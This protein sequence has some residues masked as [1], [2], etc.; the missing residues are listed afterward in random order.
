MDS[1]ENDLDE[2]E[3]CN[4]V[5]GLRVE[6]SGGAVDESVHQEWVGE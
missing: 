1:H 4:E 2:G 6:G 3:G 5:Q